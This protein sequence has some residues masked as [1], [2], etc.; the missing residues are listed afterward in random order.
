MLDIWQQCQGDQYIRKISGK[1]FRLVE[2]QEQV[3]TLGYVDTLA[4][5]S[6]LEDLLEHSKPATLNSAATLHYLLKTP[7]RYPPLP[8]GSRFGQCHE[9]GILYGGGSLTTTLAESAFYRFVFWHS[10]TAAP[11]KPAMQSQHTLFSATYR[12]EH[13]VQL[14]LPPFKQ[15]ADVL[16]HPADYQATKAL[17]SA[18]R[19]AGVKVFEYQSARDANAG[20]CIGVIAPE[21]LADRQPQKPSPYLC[22]LSATDVSFKSLQSGDLYHFAINNFLVDGRL[23]FPP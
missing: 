12:S 11:V 2:N 9:T 16:T 21:A 3:A 4:E 20:H 19:A 5:Q 23:P 10:M 8:W 7:F 18:M 1:L 13:G 15:F 17:G 22:M 6:V 14:Q